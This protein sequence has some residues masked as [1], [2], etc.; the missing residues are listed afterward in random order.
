MSK[1]K[2]NH[3]TH[4]HTNDAL[5]IMNN[6]ANSLSQQRSV[7]L[8]PNQAN[9]QIT[10]SNIKETGY[11]DVL[12]MLEIN[13][14]I[15]LNF[16]SKW[17]WKNIWRTCSKLVERTRGTK[18]VPLTSR[19]LEIFSEVALTIFWLQFDNIFGERSYNKSVF[20]WSRT[21]SSTVWKVKFV[22][23]L[24]KKMVTTVRTR[25]SVTL[26]WYIWW[27]EMLACCASNNLLKLAMSG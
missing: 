18:H 23:S 5:Y 17:S 16:K 8:P 15:M 20:L 22:H 11:F 4:T 27:Y 1:Q 6:P 14:P 7:K 10:S 26:T 3:H 19:K 2:N 12:A 24:R 9:F 21:E 25:S 13:V